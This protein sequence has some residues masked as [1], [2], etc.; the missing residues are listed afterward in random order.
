M[1]RLVRAIAAAL[2][3]AQG[4]AAEPLR[5]YSVE[6]A[7]LLGIAAIESD[8]PDAAADVAR[9][10]LA[11][12]PQDPYA[13][14]LLARAALDA[15]RLPEAQRAARLAF[16]YGATDVQRQQSARMAAVAAWNS[17]Q[18]NIAQYWLRR[19]VVA[20][21]EASRGQTLRELAAVRA[22]NP[23]DV[24][25]QFALNPSDNVNN[26][27]SSQY[28]VIDGV[29]VVG[30]LSAD[31]QALAGVTAALHAGVAYRLPGATA[32]GS[33]SIG[34]RIDSRRVELSREAREAAPN[35]DRRAF[36]ST[37]SEVFVRRI[38]RPDGAPWQWSG[39][40]GLGVQMAAG[41]FDYRFLRA[42]TTYQRGFN[43]TTAGSLTLGVERRNVEDGQSRAVLAT[44][45][46][47]GLRHALPGKDVVSVTAFASRLDTPLEG[48]SSMTLGGEI[49]WESGRRI[50]PAQLAMRL[51]YAESEFQDYAVGVILVPGGRQDRALTLA[52]DLTFPSLSVQ[53]LSPRITL[54]HSETRSNVS[55]FD[56]RRTGVLF[57]LAASF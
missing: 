1:P 24:S 37:R 31:G 20:S 33:T 45:L 10:L 36:D 43:E 55:R 23:L 29:P 52:A 5:G 21:P 54:T 17:G 6:E 13:H 25:V 27:A 48:R 38:V 47:A 53:G 49:G 46:S 57:G 11:K 15:R 16:R 50:G 8:R 18:L 32:G 30:W 41:G 40:F 22:A 4:A 42:G 44:S 12:D 26:G 56:T 7:R 9:A 3:L 14:F 51:T 34:L 28:N 35:I 39:D 19:A 2:I